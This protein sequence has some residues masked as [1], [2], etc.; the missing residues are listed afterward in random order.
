VII[1]NRREAE[2]SLATGKK[3]VDVCRQL[4]VTEVTTIAGVG[5]LAD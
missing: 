5:S 3:L 4:G 1:G 2:L